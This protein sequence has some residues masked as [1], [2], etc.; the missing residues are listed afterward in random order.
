MEDINP[1]ICVHTHQCFYLPENA[2][3]FDL[4]LFD[5]VID[6]MDTVTAKIELIMRAHQA[7]VPI[8]SS[9][10][11]GNK[12]NPVQLEVSRIDQTSVCPLARVMRRELKNR[13]IHDLKVVYSKEEPKG[14][15]EKDAPGSISFVPPVAGLIL[16]G[17]VVKDLIAAKKEV[18]MKE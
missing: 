11:T 7:G 13:G 8:I 2:D 10:G 1:K 9:M 17:E 6:A 18:I 15:R 4:S 16:A 5:Y 14:Q 12:L 3:A